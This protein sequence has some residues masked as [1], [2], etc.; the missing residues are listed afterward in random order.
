MNYR[1]V[2]NY[3]GKILVFESICMLPSLLI[4]IFAKETS[5]IFAFLVAMILQSAVG[6]AMLLLWK[7]KNKNLYS[8]EGCVIVALAWIL[9]SIFGALPFLLSGTVNNYVDA[10]FET[11]SGFTTTGATILDDIE[12]A[13]MS[14][15]YWRAFTH[16]IGGMGVLVFILALSPL[17][18]GN[19][20]SL[21]IMRAESPGP[22]VEKITPKTHLSARILYGIYI[23]L[24]LIEIVI[25]LFG[26]MPLFDAVTAAFSTAGTG[27]FSIKNDSFASYSSFCQTV[28]AV[29]MVLFGVNFNF[30]F[31]LLLGDFKSAF[32]NSEV[33][34]YFIIVASAVALITMKTVSFFG[35]VGE[36][37]H[38]S[39]FQVASIITTTGFITF[40]Y[41]IW[42]EITHE[43]LL[44]LMV[45]GACAGSTG[46]G[47][48]V[49][50]L[51]ILVKSL[52]HEIK[53]F[54]HP[55]SVSVMTLDGAVVNNDTLRRCGTYFSTYA[56]LIMISC[57]WVAFIDGL[58][59][60]TNFSAVL[61]TINNIGPGLQSSGPTESF[62]CFSPLSK[63]VLMINM[64]IG[65]LE[66]FPMLVLLAPATWT[67]KK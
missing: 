16:W 58:S 59:F 55:H 62:N 43:I 54:L 33:R 15:L 8:R 34:T 52:F 1:I 42:P 65:R 14:V 48:K 44:S 38:H 32:K 4:A 36:A 45:I 63:I 37:L 5:S 35:N 7:P 24:T 57:L 60:E 51:M 46:G 47:I 31:L 64:L 20:M 49:S 61:A 40:D 12:S 27:G 10:L 17:T 21:H 18:K 23:A 29:F 66:I 11:I 39:F 56:F 25:L 9:I 41:D 53:K 50:R 22:T 6:A 3:L 28:V 2:N 67:V 13:P 26:K 30:Y 19:G